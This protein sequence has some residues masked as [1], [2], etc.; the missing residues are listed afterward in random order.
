[1]LASCISRLP[2]RVRHVMK[3]AALAMAVMSTMGVAMAFG[4]TAVAS[5]ANISVNAAPYGA[6]IRTCGNTGCQR[7]TTLYNYSWVTL[8]SYCD[9]Q[10]AYGNYWSPRWFHISW[11]VNGWVHS[12]LVANQYGV[13][14]DCS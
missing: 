9:S 1:M 11:P 8:Y 4:G 5:A 14:L 2:Q 3:T 12:S 10:W 6:N 7:I 13:K